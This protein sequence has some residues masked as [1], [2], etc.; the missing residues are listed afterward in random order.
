MSSES[1]YLHEP[2]DDEIGAEQP[3]HGKMED[4]GGVIDMVVVNLQ[5][6]VLG[7]LPLTQPPRGDALGAPHRR[8]QSYWRGL[9]VHGPGR[10]EELTGVG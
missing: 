6:L 4:V 1:L 5:N 2:P 8:A 3:L 9:D 10:E 7:R